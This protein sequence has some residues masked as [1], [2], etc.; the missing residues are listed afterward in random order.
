MLPPGTVAPL[1]GLPV[2][3]ARSVPRDTHPSNRRA[4]VLRLSR[5][6]LEA[7][8]KQSSKPSVTV[9][10]GSKP[11]QS[12][13]LYIND[14]FFPV[15]TQTENIRHE[16]YVR[17]GGNKP[18]LPLKPF[19]TISGKITVEP[20]LD[21][22]LTSQIQQ[23]TL[24]AHN[25]KHGRGTKFID[26]PPTLS[27]SKPRKKAPL[28]GSMFVK[29]LVPRTPESTSRPQPSTSTSAPAPPPPPVDTATLDA[30]K[31]RLMRFFSRNEATVEDALKAVAPDADS[32]YKQ[33]L[34]QAITELA[35][36]VA[37]AKK[38]GPTTYRLRK[39]TYLH[40]RPYEWPNMSETERHTMARTGR[41]AISDLGY[42]ATDAAW[43]H[44]A[45]PSADPPHASSSSSGTKRPLVA[46]DAKDKKG[47]AKAPES[48]AEAKP[49]TKAAPSK[50]RDVQLPV[51]SPANTTANTSSAANRRAPG[52]GFKL[53]KT[54][55]A[56]SSSARVKS[57]R[58]TPDLPKPRQSEPAPPPRVK[59]LKESARA[60]DSDTERERSRRQSPSLEKEV[61]GSVKRKKLIK[62][63]SDDDYDEPLSKQ[64]RRK[65]GDGTSVPTGR[66]EVPA[67]RPK[68]VVKKE[69]SPSLPPPPMTKVS[70][71]SPP[72]SSRASSSR[73]ADIRAR[74]RDISHYTSS[75]DEGEI[76]P[77]PPKRHPPATLPAA[78]VT[79]RRNPISVP[80]DVD[81][82]KKQYKR[83]HNKYLGT[84][85]RL[86]QQKA[87]VNDML[88]E[89][90]DTRS[91]VTD[92]D[93]GLCEVEEL[94]AILREHTAYMDELQALQ[95]AI[96]ISSPSTFS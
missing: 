35:E 62:E 70:R 66:K 40:V 19:A 59:K 31:I 42:K 68:P 16:L 67:A 49:K 64:K 85:S 38:T 25:E 34:R 21:K 15:N 72:P 8:E 27:A 58:P 23:S 32:T 50:G 75:E 41:R 87:R 37:T 61:H 96:K 22:D 10:F 3:D 17:V 79:T 20:T 5:Q 51:P 6:A 81:A 74:R 94:S 57:E 9:D 26:T 39:A 95:K 52:S 82:Q 2:L 55:D 48:K 53:P 13:G 84:F 43:R 54:E 45:Y 71:P 1:T 63:E 77:P 73:P 83:T 92:D 76:P 47:K 4:L 93:G 28:P 11:V 91:A 24:A 29:P 30:A 80:Q 18:D 33:Q 46:K 89:L 88:Q 36:P 14:A 12:I 78:P 65:T 60:G 90:D 44:L 86:I 56:T 69:M 7:L